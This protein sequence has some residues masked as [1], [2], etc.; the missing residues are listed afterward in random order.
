MMQLLLRTEAKRIAHGE[1]SDDYKDGESCN[2]E[3]LAS[4]PAHLRGGSEFRWRFAYAQSLPS[5]D[6]NP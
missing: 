4:K 2:A 1:L 3:G 6:I 5:P